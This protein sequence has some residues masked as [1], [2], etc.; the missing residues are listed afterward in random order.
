M[1]ESGI[2]GIHTSV[3]VPAFN[4]AARLPR[5]LP[6]LVNALRELDGRSEIVLVDD[7]STDDTFDVAAQHLEGFADVRLLRLP[8]NCGKGAAVRR[9]VSA[10]SGKAI[11]FVDADLAGDI[12]DL[13]ALLA[14][15]D[16]VD[17][18]LGSRAVAGAVVHGR[19]TARQVGSSAYRRLTRAMTSGTVADTQCGF[20][21]FRGPV[22][23]LL[24]SMTTSTGF[25]FDVEI[26][27]LASA[28]GFRIEECPIHWTAVEGGHVSLRRHGLE[29][30]HDLRRARRHRQ[31]AQAETWSLACHPN[32]WTPRTVGQPVSLAPMVIRLDPGPAIIPAAT[33][34]PR[35]NASLVMD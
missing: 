31:R 23:K 18:A 19:T 20:K 4:E 25:G 14:P 35:M 24:F 30:L 3:I 15:L 7:G 21:A 29:M 12:A 10:A 28:L 11:V 34:A 2:A 16:H 27:T 9:G 1:R 26:L 17:I 32:P 5:S 13:P 8:W 33:P 22:A 6:I